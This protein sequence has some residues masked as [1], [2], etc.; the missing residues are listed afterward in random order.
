MVTDILGFVVAPNKDMVV[1]QDSDSQALIFTIGSDAKFN[2]LAG[3]SAETTTGWTATNLLGSFANYSSAVCFDAVQ[4]SNGNISVAVALQQQGS[5]QIDTFY[6]S[7]L[8]NDLLQTDFTNL[9]KLAHLVQGVD[10]AFTPESIRLGSSDDGKRPMLTVEGSLNGKH[11]LYQ[12]NVGDAKATLLELPEDMTLGKDSLIGHCTGFNFGQRGNYFLYN[13][14]AT[15]HL[16]VRTSGS[17]GTLNYDYSPGNGEL[18]SQFQHLTYNCIQTATSRKGAMFTASDIYIG[19]PTG[20]YRIPNGKSGSM[21]LVTDSV[22]DIHDIVVT[23]SGDDISLWVTSSPDK[24][25]YIYGHRTSATTITWNMPI[26]FASSVLGVAAMRNLAKNSNEL[27]LLTSDLAVWHY[28]QDP[29]STL[30]RSSKAIVQDDAYVLNFDSYTTH[31][32]LES[33]GLPSFSQKVKI[34]SS[35]WQ[36]C[37]ING[38]KYSLD[39]DAPAEIEVDSS[40]NVTIIQPAGDISPPILHVQSKLASLPAIVLWLCISS[41]HRIDISCRRRLCRD[42]QH[43]YEWESYQESQK[44]Y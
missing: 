21:E 37:T 27:F 7:L 24:L 17:Q 32:H 1:I 42:H 4:D 44:C 13:I 15:R 26:I 28:W 8:S 3:S 41:I 29:E 11:L 38:L 18:P 12:L 5:S 33:A 35:E 16:V 34:T 22:I 2:L 36:Y 31:L 40:G 19:T 14:G 10:P 25:Y 39:Q 30:W 6:A 9:A 23:T 20:V 43:L